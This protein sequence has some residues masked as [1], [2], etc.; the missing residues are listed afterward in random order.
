LSAVQQNDAVTITDSNVSSQQASNVTNQAQSAQHCMQEADSEHPTLSYLAHP[1]SRR[2]TVSC[3]SSMSEIPAGD[4]KVS[5]VER[6]RAASVNRTHKQ[7]KSLSTFQTDRKSATGC[8]D[9]ANAKRGRSRRCS[10]ASMSRCCVCPLTGL[11][12]QSPVHTKSQNDQSYLKLQCIKGHQ[13]QFPSAVTPDTVNKGITH[14]RNTPQLLQKSDAPQAEIKKARAHHPE[15][16]DERR[17]VSVS[18]RSDS[19]VGNIGA[20]RSQI[21]ALGAFQGDSGV[22]GNSF[23][24][25]EVFMDFTL[26]KNGNFDASQVGIHSIHDLQSDCEVQNGVHDSGTGNRVGDSHAESRDVESCTVNGESGID[27][28][29]AESR[30]G[31]VHVEGGVSD[32][33]AVSGVGDSHAESRIDD[34]HSWVGISHPSSEYGIYEGSCSGGDVLDVSHSSGRKNPLVNARLD[35]SV[36]GGFQS[37]EQGKTASQVQKGWRHKSRSSKDHRHLFIGSFS[38]AVTR[39]KSRHMMHS[40]QHAAQPSYCEY[41]KFSHQTG[42]CSRSEDHSVF[43]SS[44]SR[45]KSCRDIFVQK[46]MTKKNS[47]RNERKVP[48]TNESCCSM[49]IVHRP[50]VRKRYRSGDRCGRSPQKKRKQSFSWSTNVEQS[51]TEKADNFL[52]CTYDCKGI[53]QTKNHS[54]ITQEYVTEMLDNPARDINKVTMIRNSSKPAQGH[55]SSSDTE[56]QMC[57]NNMTAGLDQISLNSRILDHQHFSELCMNDVVKMKAKA[58]A[59]RKFRPTSW[60]EDLQRKMMK[61][62]QSLYSSVQS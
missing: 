3:T 41:P 24:E 11:K 45:N 32:Y 14:S 58:L 12:P 29:S 17:H 36:I 43:K 4:T 2:G 34:A 28:F 49:N 57:C 33:N 39:S 55:N 40:K 19:S 60:A 15:V 13:Q 21:Q 47:S 1:L 44:L 37:G 30:V 22:V 8:L 27:E 51:N 20:F 52:T 25:Q 50:V 26:C 56:K 48:P 42:C 38:P 59:A 62:L 61:E 16:G 5:L 18:A 6:K 31:E 10:S 7:K 53:V 35:V 54:K 23:S 9:N 46:R